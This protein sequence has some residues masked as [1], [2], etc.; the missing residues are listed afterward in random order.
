MQEPRPTIDF[1]KR[2]IM[3]ALQPHLLASDIECPGTNV[4]LV[5]A[6]AELMITFGIGPRGPKRS[7]ETEIWWNSLLD[8]MRAKE[9]K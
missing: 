4:N 7:P 5:A 6:F 1:Y 8:S 2:E 3:V 9:R